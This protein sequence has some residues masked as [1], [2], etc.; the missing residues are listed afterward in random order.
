MKNSFGRV[1]VGLSGGL[2]NQLFQYAAGR[3]LSLKLGVDLVLDISWFQEDSDRA[4]ALDVF[5]IKAETYSGPIFLPNWAKRLECRLARKWGSRRLDAPI[6]RE[7][8]FHYDDTFSKIEQP[9]YLEGYWQSE[10]YFSNYRETITEEL[11]LK[12]ET[13]DQFKFLCNQI[14]S[15]D[16]ICIHI[17]RGDY[18]TNPIAFKTH[19]VC[20]VDYVYRALQSVSIGL[21]NP[22][23]FIFSDDLEWVR[24]NLA[25]TLPYT[26]VDIA[27]PNEAHFDLAL[28]A[29][30]KHFVIANSSLSWW[31][32]WLSKN[33][34]KRIVAPKK[35]FA[36]N[37]KKVDDLIPS[38]W[39]L[40]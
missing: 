27:K 26:V 14:Q 21:V 10:H 20:S 29:Q 2:G 8:H 12:V 11:A 30:C 35:W 33:S 1:V 15:S 3:S 23:C 7:P 25:L 4:Y 28:M 5:A 16:S 40:L 34:S 38:G 19:G 31:G 17:R 13:L 39:M 9:V 32:A 36:S 6:F 37:E 24:E 18:V 22:H